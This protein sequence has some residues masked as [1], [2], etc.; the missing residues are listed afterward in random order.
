V[1]QH[2]LDLAAFGPVI[3]VI[4]LD[5]VEQAVPLARTPPATSACSK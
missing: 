2:T 4:V 5:R 3:P 1:I